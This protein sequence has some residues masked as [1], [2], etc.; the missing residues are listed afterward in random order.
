MQRN[1]KQQP[2]V[3]NQY[4]PQNRT[5]TQ[6]TTNLG[7]LEDNKASSSRIQQRMIS[8]GETYTE[9]KVWVDINCHRF[10]E[11]KYK[12]IFKVS[13]HSPTQNRNKVNNLTNNMQKLTR[14]NKRQLQNKQLNG[15]EITR[16][17]TLGN[18]SKFNTQVIIHRKGFCRKKYNA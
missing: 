5:M 3:K 14:Q 9:K 15:V 11:E 1:K 10:D 16:T 6:R 7:Y 17:R 8:L 2:D 13:Q 18:T 12:A 4:Q